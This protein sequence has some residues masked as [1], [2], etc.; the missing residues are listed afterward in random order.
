MIHTRSVKIKL[1][2]WYQVQGA[3]IFRLLLKNTIKP[4]VRFNSLSLVIQSRPQGA[5][6]WV[7]RWGPTSK[8]REKHLA[9]AQIPLLMPYVGWVCCWF[10]SLAPRGF[11]PR[12][13]QKPKLPNSKSIW[14]VRRRLNKFWRTPKWFVGKQ[15]TITVAGNVLIKHKST[16][17]NYSILPWRI[18]F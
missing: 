6:P 11:S 4:W 14:N 7:W 3:H 5:F 16:K 2:K 18:L 8:A 12:T 9:Q 15:I 10:L 1:N 17:H 13:P